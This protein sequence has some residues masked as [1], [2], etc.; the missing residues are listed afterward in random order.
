VPPVVW[1][2]CMAK[3]LVVPWLRRSTAA[4]TLRLPGFDLR[5]AHVGFMVGIVSFGQSML[6]VHLSFLCHFHSISIPYS[7][8]HPSP[9]LHSRSTR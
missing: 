1:G 9:M 2:V 5:P 3:V 6:R 8:P 7:L 4:L